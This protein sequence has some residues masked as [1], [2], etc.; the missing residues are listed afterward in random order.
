MINLL[1]CPFC[2]GEAKA[3]LGYIRYLD[4]DGNEV[5][6]YDSSTKIWF[7]AS[8]YCPECGCEMEKKKKIIENAPDG[9][10]DQIKQDAVDAWNKRVKDDKE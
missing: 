1:P 7:G 2:G 5:E 8:V 10:H 9:W 4:E 3:L 6:Y